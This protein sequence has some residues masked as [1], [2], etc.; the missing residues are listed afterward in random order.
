MNR[1]DE[2]RAGP[3]ADA[4]RPPLREPDLGV[5]IETL[6]G[7]QVPPLYPRFGRRTHRTK[8][9]TCRHNGE[10]GRRATSC[11]SITR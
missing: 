10:E 2:G 7:G 5:S 4:N 6:P 9:L 1:D 8:G 3:Y 11:I